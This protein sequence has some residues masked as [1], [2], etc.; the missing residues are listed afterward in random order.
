MEENSS[1]LWLLIPLKG[2]TPLSLPPRIKSR[3]NLRPPTS[4]I[5]PKAATPT[6]SN[7]CATVRKMMPIRPPCYPTKP[8]NPSR[9]NHHRRRRRRR[10]PVQAPSGAPSPM[11]SPISKRE[12]PSRPQAPKA[13]APLPYPPETPVLPSN[14]NGPWLLTPRPPCPL[15]RLMN[16]TSY[17]TSTAPWIRPARCRPTP[18][19]I[20]RNEATHWKAETAF[21]NHHSSNNMDNYP[22]RIIL[23]PLLVR[24]QPCI[25][26]PS[27]MTTDDL[28]RLPAKDPRQNW[29]IRLDHSAA[30]HSQILPATATRSPR[31]RRSRTRTGR[32]RHRC[33]AIVWGVISPWTRTCNASWPWMT[34]KSC[35]MNRSCGAC[36]TRCAMAA[37]SVKPRAVVCPGTAS[38][39]EPRLTTASPRHRIPPHR[40]SGARPRCAP[41]KP[42]FSE[43]NCAASVNAPWIAS[44]RLRNWRM[45]SMR[46]RR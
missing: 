5:K 8:T 44:R 16:C 23:G 6:S 10:M 28:P 33:C 20:P 38:G 36:P 24:R 39:L 34:T 4:P 31:V 12:A 22:G 40:P 26:P 29:G 42:P 7:P 25:L 27:S 21:N 30:I 32:P 37:A 45:R 19:S 2:N 43:L 41:T 46:R 18:F 35:R 14:R 1:F 13:P 15:V 3:R 11:A 9:R 17:M